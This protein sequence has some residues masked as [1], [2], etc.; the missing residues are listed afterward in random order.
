[1]CLHC[2][3]PPK[4]MIPNLIVDLLT[5]ILHGFILHLIV[6]RFIPWYLGLPLAILLELALYWMGK[7]I[8]M[9][10]SSIICCIV[11]YILSSIF[12]FIGV[13]W[14]SIVWIVASEVGCIIYARDNLMLKVIMAI[15]KLE[16][17]KKWQE[18]AIPVEEKYTKNNPWLQRNTLKYNV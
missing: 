10:E 16:K 18:K 11:G 12:L 17:V 15:F 9:V 5:F 1:M 7:I 3:L 8:W 14:I 2:L 13:W 4:H 6:G